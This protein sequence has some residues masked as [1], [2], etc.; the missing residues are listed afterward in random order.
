MKKLFL[1][2]IFILGLS[3]AS[4]NNNG[5]GTYL[6][7][8]HMWYNTY[9]NIVSLT[10]RA[11]NNTSQDKNINVECYYMPDK[12]FFGKTKIFIKSMKSEVFTIKGFYRS[13]DNIG[14]KILK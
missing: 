8:N 12:K 6:D 13:T 10:L 5:V 3:C 7:N 14:C 4:M 9:N 2:I 1:L 11:V